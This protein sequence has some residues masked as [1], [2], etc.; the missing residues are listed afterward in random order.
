M[1][2]AKKQVLPALTE[3]LQMPKLKR[4]DVKN[5]D[6]GEKIATFKEGDW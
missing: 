4:Y 5:Y 6:D 3:I 1:P 2:P